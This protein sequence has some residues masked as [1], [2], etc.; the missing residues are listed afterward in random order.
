MHIFDNDKIFQCRC[1]IVIDWLT[2]L[3]VSA[4]I[5]I[6]DWYLWL[7]DNE[8]IGKKN[9]AQTKVDDWIS[10]IFIG[11]VEYHNWMMTDQLNSVLKIISPFLLVYW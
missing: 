4:N 10:V 11:S 5:L 6:I 8:N 9:L 1:S 7:S 3:Y 2:Y